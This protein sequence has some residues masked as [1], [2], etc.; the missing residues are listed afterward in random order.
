MRGKIDRIHVSLNEEI[1]PGSAVVVMSTYFSSVNLTG[2]L[3]FAPGDRGLVVGEHEGHPVVLI[4][5]QEFW[6]DRDDLRL[7]A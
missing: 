6:I 7:L 2:S 1:I 3:G 4:N 5:F